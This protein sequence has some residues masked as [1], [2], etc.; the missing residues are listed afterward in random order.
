MSQPTAQSDAATSEPHTGESV[1]ADPVQGEPPE[2]EPPEEEPLD[3]EPSERTLELR[4]PGEFGPDADDGAYWGVPEEAYH[5]H[6][7]LSRS[8]VAEMIDRS[9]LHAQHKWEDSYEEGDPSLGT[10]AHDRVLRPD[11]FEERYDAAPD[12]CEGTTSSGSPCSNSPS[13]REDGDWYCHHHGDSSN[14]DDI[15]RL[16]ASHAEAVE[17]IVEALSGDPYASGLLLEAGE[18]ELTVLWTETFGEHSLRCRARI[19]ALNVFGPEMDVADLKTCGSAHP[20]DIGRQLSKTGSWLQPAF[21]ERGLE[22]ISD[23]TVEHFFFVAVETAAPHAVT[24][25]RVDPA[26]V[27]RARQKLSE[28]LR[29]IASWQSR[30]R[31]PGYATRDKPVREVQIPRW[32]LERFNLPPVE[33]SA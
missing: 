9:P 1:T 4:P 22:A 29:R 7:A 20:D 27:Q 18:T 19:D 25:V 26:Q 17:G 10:I 15:E 33:T 5:T 16:S 6:P 11:V 13:F 12:E 32:K 31:W 8:V 14:Q 28:C 2:E 24:P 30:D 21:Y 3:E 23:K